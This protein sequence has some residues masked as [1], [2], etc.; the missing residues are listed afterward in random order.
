MGSVEIA[1]INC[2]FL[3]N[4]ETLQGLTCVLPMLELVQGLSK[5]AQGWKTSICDFENAFK[6]CEANSHALHC[7]IYQP[8]KT[9]VKFACIYAPFDC[10]PTIKL[11]EKL[12]SNGIL[13]HYFSEWFKLHGYDALYCG[14]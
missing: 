9:K 7:Y 1:K 4:A 11:W 6:P 13:T 10:N 5:F 8:C 2:G 14:G 3:C 12:W